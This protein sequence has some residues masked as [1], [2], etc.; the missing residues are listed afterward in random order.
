[1]VTLTIAHK[2]PAFVPVA[3]LGLLLSSCLPHE[4]SP[5]SN[6]LAG[7]YANDTWQIASPE[8]AGF[9]A[10]ALNMV[11]ENADPPRKWLHAL[12]V[13]RHGRLV[14]E[15]YLTGNDHPIN[16]LYGIGLPFTARTIFG[17]EVLHDARSVSKS[18][19]SLLVGTFVGEGQNLNLDGSIA[20]Y[21]PELTLPLDDERRAITL[22]NLLTM[23]SGLD[24]HEDSVPND[25]T[26][27]FWKADLANFVL[28]R[29]LIAKPGRRF[30]YN[31]GGAALV[32]EILVKT[33]GKPLADLVRER[34]FDPMG[35]KEWEWARDIH[36]RPLAFTGLR[37]LPRDML[38][39]GRL[40]LDGGK[41][42]G[43]Q[44]VSRDWVEASLKNNIGTG[45]KI[46]PGADGELTYGYFWWSGFVSLKGRSFQWAAAF[47]NGGQRI[48][49]VPALDL[50]VVI[51][52]GSYGS[53]AVIPMA[54]ELFR[55][56]LATVRPDTYPRE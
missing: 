15:H 11:V 32:A 25:E 6:P 38:K 48:Y 56:I 49:V 24:W 33:G 43:R 3:V 47:G 29:S 28:G 23:S 34:L 13:E 55:R 7:T 22:R 10:Q 5:H 2:C 26:R 8:V 20:S 50:S 9:D 16:R 21:F 14:A 4:P 45:H 37:L 40:M 31:S 41:W 12:L 19:I 27:L 46:P 54:Q 51:T 52:A 36:G 42:Y 44:I 39:L 35:I 53:E 30:L 17:R 18:V 1:M